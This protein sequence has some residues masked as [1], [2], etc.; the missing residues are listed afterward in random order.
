MTTRKILTVCLGVIGLVLFAAAPG[1]F[2]N[3][4]SGPGEPATERDVLIGFDVFPGAAEDALIRAHGGEVRHSFWLVPVVAATIPDRAAE[5]LER[6]PNIRY[7]EPD[8]EVFAL[9]QTT[10]WGIERVE[11]PQSWS[12]STGDGISVAVLDTGID[13][14]HEDLTVTGGVNTIDGTPWGSDGSGHGTHVAGTIAALDNDRGVVG[15]A[16]EVGLYAVKV[17]DDNGSGTISSVVKGIEWVVEQGDGDGNF[18]EILNMSLGTSSDSQTLRN[19]C[20]EAYYG[21]GHLLVAAA[22]NDGNPGGNNDSLHYPAKYDSVI[23]VAASDENDRRPS[24]SS[25]GPNLELTA[26]GADILSTLPGDEYARWS[27][28]SMA[29]PH[30]AGVAALVWATNPTLYETHDAEFQNDAVRSV[31]ADTA[32]SLGW[33]ENREGYGLVRADRAVEAAMPTDPEPAFFAVT[34]LDGEVQSEPG[35][36]VTVE[37]TITNTGDEDGTQTVEFRFEGDLTESKGVTL[38]GGEATTLTFTFDGPEETGEYTYSVH[39]E[40]DSGTG[41][42]TVAELEAPTIHTF[43]LT[44]TS[45][46]RWARVRVEWVVSHEGGQLDSVETALILDGNVI[47]SETSS[48][49]GEQASGEHELRERDG[50]GETY[51]VKLTITDSAGN[52]TTEM[53]EI[54]L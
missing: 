13:E 31:L 8:A 6:N 52:S 47:D 46:P 19:A 5:A 45:N 15:V 18:I 9:S 14:N 22:G 28:T 33:G 50:H 37:A 53:R 3:A 21:Y 39:T 11:A 16:H 34:E 7:V 17:L 42:L 29:A 36:S 4:P 26:P 41:T 32:E 35:E 38:G 30:V 27:G 25:T 51:E 48:V 1:S 2:A 10:P 23:A 44:D 12:A 49:S 40:D 54:G 43:E 24:W 20:D